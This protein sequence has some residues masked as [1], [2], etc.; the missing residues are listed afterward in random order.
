MATI[1]ERAPGVFE[2]RAFVGRDEA[3][4]PVQVSRT[5]RGTKRDAKR[6][7]DQL[8]STTSSARG[9][10]TT[11]AELLDAWLATMEGSWAPSTSENQ[12]SRVALVKR[13]QIAKM[14]LAKLTAPD[15]A[16]WHIRLARRGAGEGS[17]RNQHLVLRAALSVALRWGWV[18]FN[19]AASAPLGRRKRAPRGVL[20][21]DD[22][23]AVLSA[24][25]SMASEGRIEPAAPVALRLAC[26]TG[27]RRSELAAL[28]WEELDG[29]RLVIDS[30]IAVIR[31]GTSDDG[32]RP[33]LRDD[34]TKTGTRRVVSL[35]EATLDALDALH[36]HPGMLG[37]WL[38]APGSRPI[39]PDRISAWWRRARDLAGLNTRWRLHDLR[40]WSATTTVAAGHDVRSVAARLGHANPAMTL[41]VYAHAVEA[42]DATLAGTLGAALG[43]DGV[44]EITTA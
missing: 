42:T 37:P 36:K 14:T 27:A 35:D 38:L 29:S 26:V 13:D 23:K 43:D 16:A 12:R 41:R 11:V 24:A 44:I 22:V 8:A 6:V 1:R 30:S 18:P 28:R 7:A 5:V 25:V 39:S 33:F 31:G 9:A 40:H 15:V 32:C 10:R 3:G 2:V 34:P 19:V 4:R 17:V 21:T 20:G